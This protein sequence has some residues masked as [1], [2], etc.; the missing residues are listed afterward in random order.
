MPTGAWVLLGSFLLLVA[1]F[2]AMSAHARYSALTG[3]A[4]VIAGILWSSLWYWQYPHDFDPLVFFAY[5]NPT[6]FLIFVGAAAATIVV[7]LIW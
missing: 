3:S 4:T 2:R 7:V 6:V 1:G 5:A